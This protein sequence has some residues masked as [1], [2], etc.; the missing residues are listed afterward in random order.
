MVPPIPTTKGVFPGA[1]SFMRHEI[2]PEPRGNEMSD[3]PKGDRGQR[4]EIRRLVSRLT[5]RAKQF[6]P[7]HSSAAARL[8]IF[9]ASISARRA[10]DTICLRSLLPSA[11]GYVLTVDSS[12]AGGGGRKQS[13]SNH[14]CK[15]DFICNS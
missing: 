11:A 8:P 10:G 5:G 6:E 12:P 9:P 15:D 3:S 13:G 4:G 1:L 7:M 14:R 2:A